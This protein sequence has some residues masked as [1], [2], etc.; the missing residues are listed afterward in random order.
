MKNNMQKIKLGVFVIVGLAAFFVAI[1]Y[2]GQNKNLFSS[3]ITLSSIFQNV[4]GLGVGNNVR[5]AG[6]KVGSVSDIVIVDDTSIKV[7][8]DIDHSYQKF[9]R[10]DSKMAIGSDGLMGDKLIDLTSGTMSMPNVKDGDLL[11][12]VKPLDID[13]IMKKAQN[14][15]VNIEI[16]TKEVSDI[17]YKANHSDGI[18]H[19]LLDDAQANRR[20]KSILRNTESATAHLSEDLKAAQSSFLLRGYFKKKEKEKEKEEKAKEKKE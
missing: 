16:L 9:L 1:F 14:T 8:V 5:F 6:I 18:I 4:N 2:V 20:L 15:L 17:A 12:A 13:G 11:I 3:N 19:T 10:T 7:V